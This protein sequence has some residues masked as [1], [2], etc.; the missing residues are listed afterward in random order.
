MTD[1]VLRICAVGDV[2]VNRDQPETLF[3][4]ARPVLHGA[5]ITFGDCESNYAYSERA[6]RNPACRGMMLAHPDN[7]KALTYAGFDVMTFANNHHLDAGYVAFFDTL[8]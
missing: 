4:L 7:V 8:E 5:D 1:S 2:I 6:S 3:E